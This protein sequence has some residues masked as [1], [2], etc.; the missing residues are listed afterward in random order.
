MLRN[1]D[2][3]EN[4][5]KSKCELNDIITMNING[6]IMQNIKWTRANKYCYEYGIHMSLNVK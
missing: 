3:N 4:E 2:E 5:S 1:T 6:Y